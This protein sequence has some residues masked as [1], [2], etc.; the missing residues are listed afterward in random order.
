MIFGFFT[1]CERDRSRSIQRPLSESNASC[2]WYFYRF[3]FF[4]SALTCLKENKKPLA[5]LG[6]ISRDIY[7]IFVRERV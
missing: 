3:H 1:A 6:F 5:V 2:Q 7:N 4:Y